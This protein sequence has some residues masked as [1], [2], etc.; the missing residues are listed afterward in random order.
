[1]V[2]PR[3]CIDGMLDSN[4]FRAYLQYQGRFD[5]M[6]LASKRARG[7]KK[8]PDVAIPT[9]ARTEVYGKPHRLGSKQKFY[10]SL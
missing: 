2:E 3:R 10:Y 7:L 9:S 1:M 8:K 5:E 6:K 4:R